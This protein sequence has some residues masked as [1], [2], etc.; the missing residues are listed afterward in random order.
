M[1]DAMLAIEGV[2]GGGTEAQYLMEFVE[3]RTYTV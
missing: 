1:G 2:A 3:P